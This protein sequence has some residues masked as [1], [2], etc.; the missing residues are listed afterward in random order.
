MVFPKTAA[1]RRA[2]GPG[3]SPSY[4]IRRTS[5]TIMTLAQ[6]VG[7]DNCGNAQVKQSTYPLL[8][9]ASRADA[10]RTLIAHDF[11]DPAR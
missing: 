8:P 3:V 4:P 9:G 6:S 11:L 1:M 2:G 7:L 10:P 5:G